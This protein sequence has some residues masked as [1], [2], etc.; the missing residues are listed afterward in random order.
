MGTQSLMSLRLG[1]PRRSGVRSELKPRYLTRMVQRVVKGNYGS[2]SQRSM[3]CR[4]GES[5]VGIL[6]VEGLEGRVLKVCVEESSP[7]GWKSL[8]I[9]ESVGLM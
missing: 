2:S 7:R 8:E 4:Y 3:C 9:P 1:K 6:E 5:S